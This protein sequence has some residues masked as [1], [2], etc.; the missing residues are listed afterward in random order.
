MLAQLVALS[1]CFLGAANGRQQIPNCRQQIHMLRKLSNLNRRFPQHMLA[2]IVAL[3]LCFLGAAVRQLQSPHV[4][5]IICHQ[6]PTSRSYRYRPSPSD[7]LLWRQ[8]KQRSKSERR[9]TSWTAMVYRHAVKPV[10]RRALARGHAKHLPGRPDI[11][12]GPKPLLV[13]FWLS[14]K[15]RPPSS[16]AAIPEL[17][18]LY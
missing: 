4:A 7:T 18:V 17:P 2:Q 11:P 1:L 6:S 16:S 14:S 15:A 9:L 10:Y 5:P 13:S 12:G 3:S 8:E